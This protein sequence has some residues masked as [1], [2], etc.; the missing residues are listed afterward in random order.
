MDSCVFCK[1]AART[2]PA[3]IV[4]ENDH[5]IA[6]K[7]LR[8]I[9]PVHALVIPKKHL[10]GMGDALPDD[11][12]LLGQVLLAGPRVAQTLGLADGGYRL[13]INQGPD[14]GQSVFHLH[15]H[16]IGGR[17]MDWPPG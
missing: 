12:A 5:V 7:D 1:I 16:V 6:F 15:C 10:A 4:F 14:A 9:A 17:Q 11:G 3:E 8:P 13:V 2:I